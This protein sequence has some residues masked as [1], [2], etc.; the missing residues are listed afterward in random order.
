MIIK[1]L[2]LYNNNM[3]EGIQYPNIRYLPSNYLLYRKRTVTVP[4]HCIDT[5]NTYST[6]IVIDVLNIIHRLWFF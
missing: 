3:L 4:I 2:Y 1:S 5:Y 6:I